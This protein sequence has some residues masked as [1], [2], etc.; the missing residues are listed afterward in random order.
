VMSAAALATDVLAWWTPTLVITWLAPVPYG[1][2]VIADFLKEKD[3]KDTLPGPMLTWAAMGSL[4]Q[5]ARFLAAAISWL[6]PLRADGGVVA[7]L[8]VAPA[9]IAVAAGW[10]S[11]ALLIIVVSAPFLLHTAVWWSV[12]VLSLYFAVL[13]RRVR[14]PSRSVGLPLGISATVH[15]ILRQRIWR[16]DRRLKRS[17]WD[18]AEQRC[19]RAVG[20]ASRSGQLVALRLAMA[21]LEL[22]HLQEA[23]DALGLAWSESDLPVR[24]A[25]RRLQGEALTRSAQPAAAL[26]VLYEARVLMSGDE[27][28]QARVSLALADALIDAAMPSEAAECARH[29]ATWFTGRRY[30]AE[31]FRSSRLLA[32]AL[33]QLDDL[34]GALSAIDGGLSVVASVRW[35]RQYLGSSGG[36][37]DDG[38]VVFGD[39]SV[40][41]REFVRLQILEVQIKMDPRVEV[42]SK[43]EA[44]RLHDLEMYSIMLDMG[45]AGLDRARVDL[46]RARLFAAAGKSVAATEAAL[47]AMAELDEVRHDLRSQA[48]RAAWSAELRRAVSMVMESSVEDK[49]S[50]RV[51]EMIEMARV[52]AFPLLGTG[53]GQ[54]ELAL[55]PPPTVRV[56]GRASIA[57]GRGGLD[58]I[59]L[60]PIDIEH[61]AASAAGPG[62][63]WLSFWSEDTSLT[64]SLVPPTG[65]VTHG[66]IDGHRH[67]GLLDVLKE[68]RRNLPMPIDAEGEREGDVDIRLFGSAFRRYP[69]QEADLS[70][71]LGDL[72]IPAALRD[73]AVLRHRTGEQRLRLAIAPD[74][75]LAHVP[76]ALLV[77][78]PLMPKVNSLRLIE[79]A[80]W[81]L[82]PSA[83]LLVLAGDRPAAPVARPLRLAILDPADVPALPA[84]RSLAPQLTDVRVLGGR[85]WCAQPATPPAVL[86]ALAAAGPNS[87]VLFGC[88]A[89]RGDERRPSSSALVLASSDPAHASQPLTA[90]DIFAS[91]IPRD[92]FPAQISLQACDTSD[93]ASATSGEWLSLAPAFLVAGARVVGTTQFPLVDT[94]DGGLIEAMLSGLDLAESIRVEQVKALA[95]WRGH[96]GSRLPPIQDSPLAWAAHAICATGRAEATSESQNRTPVE[97]SQSLL[98]VLRMASDR[99]GGPTGDCCVTSAHVLAEFLESDTHLLSGSGL[100]EFSMFT[101]LAVCCRLLRAPWAPGPRQGVRPSAE[102]LAAFRIAGVNAARTTGWLETEHLVLAVLDGPPTPG[103][104]LLGALG[105]RRRLALQRTVRGNLRDTQMNRRVSAGGPQPESSGLIGEVL[106]AARA[107]TSD[108]TRTR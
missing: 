96:D 87:T 42:S 41:L 79:V 85:H 90:G 70:G 72:L 36:Q 55:A 18:G 53:R 33:W 88:H 12:G 104:R 71:R 95:R 46:L 4:R 49:D 27:E 34:D 40:L 93:L 19:A 68:L 66:R 51:A 43:D 21:R 64:W 106:H 61:A 37:R 30:I 98:K 62:A 3:L 11:L 50:V 101:R 7:G 92:Q 83:T 84:A 100:K 65:E 78:E 8:V 57:R 77:L 89:I 16:I 44:D 103:L 47:A 10:P 2:A 29:A 86:D 38:E 9:A 56:R 94:T 73:A 54:D 91:G 25:V 60:G 6:V 63:W 105:L 15:P 67:A 28:H 22:D 26:A 59:S 45:G 35:L 102:L 14:P 1:I 75:L 48:D 52:Q 80:D 31:R 24:A 74:P 58:Q 99:A 82:A 23:Q 32:L 5:G 76:W 107:G 108:A 69:D 20:D 17:D 13:H 97:P 81:A 39:D